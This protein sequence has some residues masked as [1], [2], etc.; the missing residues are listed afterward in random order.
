MTMFCSHMAK[1]TPAPGA[2]QH[3]GKEVDQKRIG[4]AHAGKSGIFRRKVVALGEAV[5]DLK[6]QRQVAQ[7][8]HH[9]GINAV[10]PLK[11]SAAEN[12][13]QKNGD[14]E[15]KSQI[16]DAGNAG[17]APAEAGERRAFR[18]TARRSRFSSN[19]RAKEA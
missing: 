16:T 2:H 5:D 9:A 11:D 1:I 15:I 4:K 18:M 14:G 19:S 6:M 17:L 12:H 13:C 7:I 10:R 8:V 3:G